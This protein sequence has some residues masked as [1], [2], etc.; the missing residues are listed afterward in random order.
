MRERERDTVELTMPNKQHND[1]ADDCGPHYSDNRYGQVLLSVPKFPN[2]A[3]TSRQPPS[4][5]GINAGYG[6]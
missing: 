5:N 6:G 4:E 1:I 3:V 2:G